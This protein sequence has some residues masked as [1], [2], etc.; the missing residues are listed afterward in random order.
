MNP[1]RLF[2]LGLPFLA[3]ATLTGCNQQQQP[4]SGGNTDSGALTSIDYSSGAQQ[5]EENDPAGETGSGQNAAFF[6]V[7]TLS[8]GSFLPA[9]PPPYKAPARRA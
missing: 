3:M 4:T 2:V 8:P 9:A 7:H 1:K 5:E 6:T